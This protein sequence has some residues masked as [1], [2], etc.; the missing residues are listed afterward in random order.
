MGEEEL[1]VTEYHFK[2]FFCKKKE[3]KT[4]VSEGEKSGQKKQKNDF[5]VMCACLYANGSN[6]VEKEKL[7]MQER[8]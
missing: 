1:V 2:E 8:I 3:R 7:K 5:R 6:L 4:V